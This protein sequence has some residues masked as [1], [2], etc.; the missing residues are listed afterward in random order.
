MSYWDN[1]TEIYK[2]QAEKGIKEYKQTLEENDSLTAEERITMLEEELVD[3]LCYLEHL[4]A[5]IVK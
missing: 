1:I 4:K 3:G 5:K 2:K